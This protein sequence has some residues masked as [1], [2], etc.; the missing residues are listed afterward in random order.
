ME[1]CSSYR[2]SPISVVPRIVIE[3]PYQIAIAPVPVG[4]EKKENL[5]NQANQ[6]QLVRSQGQGVVGNSAGHPVLQRGQ[7]EGNSC[8][9]GACGACFLLQVLAALSER[10]MC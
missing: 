7:G 9:K 1:S 4:G 2:L 3:A 8:G 10:K 6:I 5:K